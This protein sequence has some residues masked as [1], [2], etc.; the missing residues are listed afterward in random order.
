M[1]MRSLGWLLLVI[2]AA[3]FVF[4]F[5][6]FVSVGLRPGPLKEEGSG[7][8]SLRGATLL[9]GFPTTGPLYYCL[10]LNAMMPVTLIAVYINWASMK[11]FQLN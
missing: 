9:E 2:A 1:Y 5:Y 7:T 11:F 3:Y 6:I 8:E 10:L 4:N